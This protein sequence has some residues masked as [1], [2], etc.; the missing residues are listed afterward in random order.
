MINISLMEKTLTFK[1][2]IWC[3]IA[4]FWHFRTFAYF[5]FMGQTIKWAHWC[6]IARFRRFSN[7]RLFQLFGTDYNII[8][9]HHM[10]FLP[11]HTFRLSN[12]WRSLGTMYSERLEFSL[13][14][15][16]T[17]N[18]GLLYRKLPLLNQVGH[19]RQWRET[20]STFCEPS[21]EIKKHQNIFLKKTFLR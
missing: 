18:L 2:P 15:P 5:N 16:L 19:I 6:S 7:V 8:Q 13:P 12:D 3:S 10:P 9:V 21:P 17:S 1:W 14:H 11:S 20:M 4:C